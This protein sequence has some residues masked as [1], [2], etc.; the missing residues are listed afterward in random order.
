MA[1]KLAI[2]TD[3]GGFEDKN[4][5]VNRLK[6]EGHSVVDCGTFTKD[7]TDYPIFAG[8]VAELVSCGAV[9]FGIILCRSGI[10]M[11][12]VANRYSGVRAALVTSPE[13]AALCRSHNNANVFVYGSDQNAFDCAELVSIFL[14]T[15]HEGGR[16]ARRVQLIEHLD[17]CSDSIQ[18]TTHALRFGQSTWFTGQLTEAVIT[19]ISPTGLHGVYLNDAIGSPTELSL[20][21]AL[22]ESLL[23]VRAV[24]ANR[25]GIV[26]IPLPKPAIQPAELIAQCKK[27]STAWE[28]FLTVV[29]LP[30]NRWNQETIES[31]S[32][33]GISFFLEGATSLNQLSELSAAR[34]R[35]LEKRRSA[36]LSVYEQLAFIEVL[37]FT[38]EQ[39]HAPE[40]SENGASAFVQSVSATLLRLN[41]SDQMAELN[42]V[43]VVPIYACFRQSADEFNP[44]VQSVRLIDQ[45]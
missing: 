8:R 25:S 6:A 44:V 2:G 26:C 11:S 19:R 42:S 24:T 40:L 23:G 32:A 31:L 14:K 17:V 45:F 3:H 15:D 18:P 16:H 30:S 10:G 9:E 29:R 41:Y 35:G 27:L 7:S 12:I 22:R 34:M 39:T 20:A 13:T 37:P 43:G 21:N 33:E 4:L 38:P 36:G 5:L 1:F 28:G